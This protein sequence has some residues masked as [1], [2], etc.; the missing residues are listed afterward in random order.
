MKT[1]YRNMSKSKAREI[2]RAY[3]NREGTQKALA[4]RFGVSQPTVHRAVSG[5]S[6]A[7]GAFGAHCIEELIDKQ[8]EP[9]QPI[10]GCSVVS[11]GCANFKQR[12]CYLAEL[13]R[14]AKDY[15]LA[16][17]EVK[18]KVSEDVWALLEQRS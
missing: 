3:L 16:L 12:E 2:Q 1:K 17:Q 10:T 13:Q 18:E 15:D 7:R 14:R 5:I 11:P 4:A 6:W 8:L 9:W